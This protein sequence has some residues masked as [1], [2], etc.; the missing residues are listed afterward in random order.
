MVASGADIGIALDGDA[1]R[2]IVVDEKGRMVDGD[3]LMAL[4]ARRLGARAASSRAAGS[5]RRSMSNL[6]LERFLEA[7]GWRCSAP[8]SATATCS[9][10]CARGYNVGGEQS[11]HII[12]VR[13]CDD[14]RRAG[15]RRCRCSPRWSTAGRAGERAAA[16]VRSA[17][18]AAQERPLHRR[19]S[20]SRRHA[21]KAAIA[22]GRGASWTGSGPAGDP[23][24][25]HRAA[26]PRDGRGRGRALVAEVVDTICEAV[27]AA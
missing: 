24:V 15:R 14:R 18:A 3:Q 16:P 13:S 6:G 1:D 4:I 11:G 22:D 10:R 7:R 5:S 17:A 9:R 2:L 20:R 27:Q 19:R 21:V 23:Q 12:L 25:G 8:R 26:D